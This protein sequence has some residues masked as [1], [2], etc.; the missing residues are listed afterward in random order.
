MCNSGATLSRR[1]N[2]R[3]RSL[4]PISRK[5]RVRVQFVHLD[6]SPPMSKSSVSKS[7]SLSFPPQQC[8][9]MNENLPPL[10]PPEL[11]QHPCSEN[12]RGD[13]DGDNL[14]L[15]P[16]PDELMAVSSNPES[17]LAGSLNARFTQR[18]FSLPNR[19]KPTELIRRSSDAMLLDHASV[20]EESFS[21]TIQRGITLKRVPTSDRSAPDCPQTNVRASRTDESSSLF[22]FPLTIR[23]T[24]R[25][26]L[27][28][29]YLTRELF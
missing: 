4:P 23:E 14:P 8:I 6:S 20:S 22:D 3:D 1:N 15:P 9:R 17:S 11:L 26:F 21:Q 12:I 28:V 27:L 18:Q 2:P 29:N 16:L 25:A 10:P 24:K 19:G 7:S 5:S 13:D